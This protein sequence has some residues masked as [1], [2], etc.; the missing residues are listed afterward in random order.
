MPTGDDPTNKGQEFFQMFLKAKEFTE[1]LLKENE[2][3]RFKVA[4]LESGGGAARGGR[5][6]RRRPRQGALR[7]HPPARGEAGRGR[8][9][10]PEGRGGE[11]G[12][13][14]PLHRDRGAEQ[15][16]GQPLRGLLPAPLHARLQGGRPHRPGDRHQPDRRGGVPHLDGQREDAASSSWRPP[17]ARTCAAQDVAR[18]ARGR[19]ARRPRPARTSSRT[20]S[21]CA[22]RRPTTSRSR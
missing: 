12:V 22:S 7:A 20:R 10:L 16:P 5:R 1:E 15:Q 19:S 11:Q 4:R 13:R 14:R 8:D 2:R 6:Q 9:P 17:K 18:S 3:L 21:R